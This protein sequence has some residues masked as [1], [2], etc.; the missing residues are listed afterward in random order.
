MIPAEQTPGARAGSPT[1]SPR[2][3]HEQLG[4]KAF[5]CPPVLAVAILV[6][7]LAALLIG[8]R[9]PAGALAQLADPALVELDAERLYS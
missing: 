9:A 3:P 8:Y 5:A 7:G 6:L 1:F 2:R 4:A